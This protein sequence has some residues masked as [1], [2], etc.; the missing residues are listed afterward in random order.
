MELELIRKGTLASCE[1]EK[2][3]C[4]NYWHEWIDC[5]GA[6]DLPNSRCTECG[7]KM[8][9]ETYWE[10]KGWYAARYSAPG[11]LDCTD[12]HYGRNKRKLVAEVDELYGIQ[13]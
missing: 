10:G 7:G 4:T 13:E 2:C 6:D 3:G 8:D 1:C 12:W 5:G 11:Y 9:K